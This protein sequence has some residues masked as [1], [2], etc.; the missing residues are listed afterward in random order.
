MKDFFVQHAIDNVWCAPNRD[1]QAIVQPARITPIGGV[2]NN[3]DL[4]W[5][6][7]DLPVAN[8]RFHV[9]Q[10]GNLNPGLLGLLPSYNTWSTMANACNQKKMIIDIYAE[11]GVEMPRTQVWYMV[12]L[13]KNL[14][15]AVQYQ[16]TIPID[17][18]NDL[19][20]FRFYSNLFFQTINASL[21]GDYV[22]VAG[23]SMTST[24]AI[25]ALANSYIAANALT[26]HVNAYVNGFKVNEIS[27]VTVAVGDVAEFVYDSS[28]YKVINFPISALETFTSTLD[29]L[30]KY[31]FHYPNID[32]SDGIDYQADID[33][34]ILNPGTSPQY[35]GLYCH[36]N[37]PNT[38]RMVTHKDYA[39]PVTY[40]QAYATQQNWNLN[41]LTIQMQVRLSGL[42]RPLVDE[43]SR[44]K[45]LYRLS[46]AQV[47]AA[48][49][50]P[51][52]TVPVWQAANLEAAAYTRIMRSNY[53]DI[54]LQLVQDAYGYNAMSKLIGNTPQFTVPYSGRQSVQMEVGLVNASTAYEYDSD[55]NL[56]GWYLNF[57]EGGLY[58]TENNN[59]NLV[60][61]I[62]G[63]GSNTLDEVYGQT[64]VVINPTGDYR[65]YTCPIVDG[66]PTNVWT[67]VTGTNSYV[68]NNGVLT[69]VVNQSL[70]YTLVRGNRSFLAYDLSLQPTNGPIEFSLTHM[71]TRG[72]TTGNW[73]MQIPM[74]ELDVFLNGK[75][76]IED[77]D[78]FV[79]FPKIVITNKEYLINPTTQAQDVGIRFTGFCNSD[80]TRT[81]STDVGFVKWGLLSEN[82]RYDIREDK[83]L[84][85][86]V[87]GQLYDRSELQFQED[88][89]AILVPDASNGKPYLIRDIVV[90]LRGTTVTDTYTLRAASLAIDTSVSDYLTEKLVETIP[91]SA[92]VIPALYAI[93]SPFLCRIIYDLIHNVL[94]SSKIETTYSDQDVTEIV[95]PYLYLL[96][97]DPTQVGQQPDSNFVIIHPHNLNTVINVNLYQYIFIQR[98]VKIYMNNLVN[99]SNFISLTAS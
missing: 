41:N 57:T 69:W 29:S 13:D 76:L 30:S 16:P 48:F 24:S 4:P 83:V 73:V 89:A 18:D 84:R 46:D 81:L 97:F 49:T 37:N 10:I 9:Y 88:N 58:L 43:N 32:G 45:E 59:A 14:I 55:G 71:Q 50:G 26:G 77:L 1:M 60:E 75:S 11:S 56:L 33:F 80:L 98:V 74:G 61:F 17:F 90:P 40:L 63:A 28:V 51:D 20:Y 99:I 79:Q 86:I 53:A 87:G 54:T 21:A 52:S 34:F 64:T 82:N 62:S 44:I 72:N 92:D 38:V 93:F 66:L 2:W 36:R 23:G 78:Y 15:I 35:K 27:L 22:Q 42:V 95:A 94:V 67:D 31:L 12:T 25:V 19:L 96:A 91:N 6:N 5:A 65:M 39:I 7:I 8:A 85:I 68:I 47:L 70:Y 3:F